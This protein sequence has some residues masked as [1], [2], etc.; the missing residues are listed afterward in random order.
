MHANNI[1]VL[2][3][4]SFRQGSSKD[5]DALKLTDSVFKSINQKMHIHGIFCHLA[6]AFDCVNHKILLVKLHYYGSQRP[7]PDSVIVIVLKFEH[8]A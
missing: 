3:Q 2:E 7:Q 4:F 5:D 6:K 1:L 8:I